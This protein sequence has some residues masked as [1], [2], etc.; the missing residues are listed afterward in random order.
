MYGKKKLTREGLYGLALGALNGRLPAW[1][2]RSDDADG[3]QTGT[4]GGAR[5]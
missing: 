4:A 3:V 2:G 5:V 1:A